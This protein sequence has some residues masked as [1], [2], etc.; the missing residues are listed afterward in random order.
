MSGEVGGGIIERTSK[1]WKASHP[2]QQFL[3]VMEARAVQVKKSELVLEVVSRWPEDAVG[4]AP[5]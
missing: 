1:H 2:E 3:R 4:I 5:L